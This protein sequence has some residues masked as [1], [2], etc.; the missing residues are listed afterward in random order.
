MRW[1]IQHGDALALLAQIPSQSV[2][3]VVTDPPYSSGG[4]HRSDRMGAPRDKY[5]SG[6]AQVVYPTFSGD[7][8]DQR[9]YAHWCALWIGECQRIVR[10]GGYMLIFT[11]WRQLPI[12]TDS[13]QA[14][15]FIWRGIIAWDKTEAAR[16]P[17]TGYFRHQCEYIVWGSNGHLPKADGHGPFPGCYRTP[18]RPAEKQHLTAKPLDLMRQLIQCIPSGGTIL[19]PFAGSGSTGVAAVQTGHSFIGIEREAS[20]VDIARSRLA[21]TEKL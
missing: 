7:N 17:H 2:D 10:A 12:T 1:D 14:G 13:L 5:Q 15:G 6:G 20:Y 19:D 21:A 4:L 3:A 9:S 16:A 11:D 18:I 8:R